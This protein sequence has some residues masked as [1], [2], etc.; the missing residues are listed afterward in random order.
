MEFEI[1]RKKLVA[2]HGEEEIVTI[3]EGVAAIG[4]GC[5]RDKAFI[6]EIRLPEAG[7]RKVYPYAFAGT[8]IREMCFPEKEVEIKDRAFFGCKL[9]RIVG[10]R[11]NFKDGSLVGCAVAHI[12]DPQV[13]FWDD[14]GLENC[15]V[16]SWGATP[17]IISSYF[18]WEF[19]QRHAQKGVRWTYI[20][21]E[22]EK[23][24][25]YQKAERVMQEKEAALNAFR[26]SARLGL[27]GVF[28]KNS[29]KTLAL[30]EEEM[31]L[32]REYKES[33]K[34]WWDA[35]NAF[36]VEQSLV[37]EA[38]ALYREYLQNGS[39]EYG[40]S[41]S[42][43]VVM[44]RMRENEKSPSADGAFVPVPDVTGI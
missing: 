9:E 13:Y 2:Y 30:R 44:Q 16:H 22:A 26:A 7:L 4:E 20:N 8:G 28:C 3:P 19:C 1:V 21:S 10:E 41:L 36:K 23:R 35:Y 25:I 17:G 18:V 6:K 29:P 24:A 37:Q 15:T 32:D 12:Y 11:L 33:K 31:R 38:Q 43:D 5:F 40:G 14:C 42:V 34:L 39:R 27:R